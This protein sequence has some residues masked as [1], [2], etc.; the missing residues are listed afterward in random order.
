MA[1]NRNKGVQNASVAKNDGSKEINCCQV[2]EEKIEFDKMIEL[3]KDPNIWIADSGS[4]S[5]STGHGFGMID[6]DS[7]MPGGAMVTSSGHEM[8]PTQKGKLPVTIC[9][10]SGNELTQMTLNSVKHFPGQVFNL[11]STAKLQR[12]GWKSHGDKKAI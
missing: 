10:K 11:M 4:S 9:D 3:L 6:L 1:N 2:T 8:V 12:N 5:H 7:K